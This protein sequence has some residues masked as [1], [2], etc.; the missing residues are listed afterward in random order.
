MGRSA[1]PGLLLYWFPLP[2][3]NQQQGRLLGVFASTIIALGSTP[4]RIR[5]PR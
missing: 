1:H 3:L 2:G 5:S 4:V